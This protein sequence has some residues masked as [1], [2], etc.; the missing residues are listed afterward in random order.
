MDFWTSGSQGIKNFNFQKQFVKIRVNSWSDKTHVRAP[1][2]ETRNRTYAIRPYMATQHLIKIIPNYLYLY[3]PKF[4]C[5][6]WSI[7]YRR[8]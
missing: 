6:K 1:L 5:H 2:Q 7:C 8:R 4:I 3:K